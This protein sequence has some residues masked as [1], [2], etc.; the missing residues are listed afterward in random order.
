M[1][2]NSLTL[3]LDPGAKGIGE[4]ACKLYHSNSCLANS[5]FFLHFHRSSSY[6]YWNSRNSNLCFVL[7]SKGLEEPFQGIHCS[8]WLF[9]R[10]N[11]FCH[12]VSHRLWGVVPDQENGGIKVNCLSHLSQFSWILARPLLEYIP[13]TLRSISQLMTKHTDKITRK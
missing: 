3:T 8:Y 5:I 6:A 1:L 13:V 11:S 4:P 2:P 12:T 10:H 9:D 7:A